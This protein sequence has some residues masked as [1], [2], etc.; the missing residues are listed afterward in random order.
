MNAKAALTLRDYVARQVRVAGVAP[1]DRTVLVETFRDPAGELSLALL[2]P[3]GSKLHHGLKLVIQ[4]RLHQRLGITASTLHGDDGV[5]IRLPGTD[6]PPLDIF[7]GL[8]GETGEVLLRQVLGDSA[9]F[10]LRFRQDA[11][12]ALLMPRP[13]PGKRTPLWLQRLRA[14]DLLQVVRTFPDFP[15]VVEAYRE[16]LVDDLDLPRLRQFLD[17]VDRGEVKVVTRVAEIASPF[18]SELIFKFTPAFIYEWDEP[19]RGDLPSRPSEVDTDLLDPLIDPKIAALWVDPAAVGRVESRLRGVGLPPR[20][21]D[22]MAETLRR[23]GDLG[24]VE[25]VGPMAG[26]VAILESEARAVRINFTASSPSMRWILSEE[27]GLYEKAFGPDP[28]D[29][30][31][32]TIID[33][34][35]C[36]HALIGLHEIIARYPIGPARATEL[37]E[38]SAEHG[39]LVRIDSEEGVRWADRRNLDEVRRLSIAIKRKESVAVTPE[40]FAAFIATRQRV[41]E[42]TRREGSAAVPLVLEE[43]QGFSATAEVWETEILPRR[44]RDYR[45]AWLDEAFATGAWVWRGETSGR[46]KMRV[47]IVSRDWDVAWRAPAEPIEPSESALPILTSLTDRGPQFPVDLARNTGFDPSIARRGLHELAGIGLVTND[48]FDPVRRS[49]DAM[50]DALEAAARPHTGR[51][52]RARPTMRRIASTRPERRWSVLNSGDRPH[53]ETSAL[54]W[55]DLLIGRYGILTREIVEIDPFCPPWKDLAPW[56]ARAELRGELRRGYFVEGLSGVQYATDDSATALAQLGGTRDPHPEPLWISSLDPAN[57]YGAGAPLDVALLEGGT[58]RL[59]R[60]PAQ[61]LVLIQGRP[62]LIIEGGGK[63]LTGLGSASEAD[64]KAALALLPSLASSSR[65][66]IKVETYNNAATLASPAAAWLAEVGFV[67]DPPGMA[68]YAGWS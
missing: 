42:S 53:P 66:M 45:P 29:L 19:R 63:R 18:A 13:D 68:F 61:S 32:K 41:H 15:I 50:I 11:G 22:E 59:N 48:R 56:L 23:L 30:A 35:L 36:T 34:F 8:T 5:L 46:G 47:A 10:G 33:R 58:A 6:T 14:K 9:L 27:A 31:I 24:E 21:A 39:N 38:T 1:D 2:T 28:E 64:L 49:G 43:L 52:F 51:A 60:A 16:C 57:I 40:T 65:R 17:Q 4:A 67:R 3:H 44:I 37:L 54:G 20:T 26:F 12:R 25:L 62:V 7:E 55:A